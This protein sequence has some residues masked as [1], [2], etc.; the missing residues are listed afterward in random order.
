MEE[1]WDLK[2]MHRAIVTSSTYRQ[3]STSNPRKQ[4]LDPENILLSRG[5]RFRLPAEFIRDA[6]LTA[7]GLLNPKAG[8]PSV[9]APQPEGA[10]AGAFGDPKW[11]TATGPDRFRRALY[12]HRK[13]AAPYAAFAAFDAPPHSTC[14]MQRVRSNTALQALAQL[15]DQMLVEASQALAKRIIDEAPDDD[16]AR[17]N[18]GFQLC[19]TRL[20]TDEELRL[21]L[22]Y[23]QAQRSRLELDKIAS[24]TVAGLASEVAQNTNDT[25]NL[26]AWTHVSRVLLNLDEAISK[27]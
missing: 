11:P 17:V 14:V 8:G 20:P 15:N 19:L 23:F 4:E 12:T 25:A 16:A 6:A 21:L 2:Q 22:A 1:S 9:F 10:L 24:A 3:A 13:R 27:E 7:S 26:A 5:P 18:Y